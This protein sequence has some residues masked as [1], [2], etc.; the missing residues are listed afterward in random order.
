MSAHDAGTCQ[1]D[2]GIGALFRHR[3][4]RRK[5]SRRRRSPHWTI[6]PPAA[7]ARRP[8]QIQPLQVQMP[9][10]LVGRRRRSSD[11]P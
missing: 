1:W 6:D 10:L 11:P 4:R 2:G 3:R 7:M 5:R 9:P 8:L